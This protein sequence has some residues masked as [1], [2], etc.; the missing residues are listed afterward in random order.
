[1]VTDCVSSYTLLVGRPPF[2][3]SDV[4]SIYDR[5]KHNNYEFPPNKPISADAQDLISQILTQDPKERPTLHEIADHSF[6]T[7]GT[8]PPFIPVTAHEYPPSFGH[9]TRQQSKANFA[10][11]RHA[12]L[13]D[14]ETDLRVDVAPD[15]STSSRHPNAATV[16]QQKQEREFH[17]AVQPASPISA[18]LKSAREPLLVSKSPMRQGENRP[19]SANALLRKL[20]AAA[21]PPSGATSLQEMQTGELKG[22]KMYHARKPSRTKSPSRQPLQSLPT[23]VEEQEEARRLYDLASQKA[24]IVTQMAAGAEEGRYSGKERDRGPVPVGRGLADEETEN[25]KPIREIR[26]TG[27]SSTS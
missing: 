15:V 3:T 2:Q 11:V 4:K 22:E 17:K 7:K 10:R 13:L 9:I 18:L 26:R 5:I 14:V 12:V 23:L 21:P 19:P 27:K 24:R 8:F 16:Q 25:I 1:M 6:F 20:S